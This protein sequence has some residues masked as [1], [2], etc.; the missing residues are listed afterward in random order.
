MGEAVRCWCYYVP[1][2]RIDDATDASPDK[3]SKEFLQCLLQYI[4]EYKLS[5]HLS[6]SFVNSNLA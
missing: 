2:L 1:K 3:R 6:I 4:E 5:H